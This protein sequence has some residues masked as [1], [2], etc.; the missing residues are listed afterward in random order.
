MN[1]RRGNRTEANEEANVE[2]KHVHMR[3]PWPTNRFTRPHFDHAH[4]DAE[5]KH[6]RASTHSVT[7]RRQEEEALALSF[8][9]LF[10]CL[11][12]VGK[13]ETKGLERRF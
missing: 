10:E 5:T 8:S 2:R 9:F 13:R 1:S 6:V 11:L 12:L 4:A 7:E 3:A